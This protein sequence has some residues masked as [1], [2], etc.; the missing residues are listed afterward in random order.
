MHW[1]QVADFHISCKVFVKAVT[2]CLVTVDSLGKNKSLD[3]NLGNTKMP[4]NGVF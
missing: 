4:T 2:T 3:C 1:L